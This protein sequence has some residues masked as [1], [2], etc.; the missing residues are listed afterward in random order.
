MDLLKGTKKRIVLN[1]EEKEEVEEE[2]EE[3]I[4]NITKNKFIKQLKKL[5]ITKTLEEDNIENEEQRYMLKEINN[6]QRKGRLSEDW[7][8]EIISLIFKKGKKY[9]VKNYRGVTLIDTKYT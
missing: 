3:K 2:K 1:L 5:K 9:E 7:N 6:M 8:K 4:Q